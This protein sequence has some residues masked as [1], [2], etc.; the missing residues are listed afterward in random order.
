MATA[1]TT[2]TREQRVS[3]YVALDA[4]RDL[5]NHLPDISGMDAT[6]KHVSPLGW[7][8]IDVG[9]YNDTGSSLFEELWPADEWDDV[10]ESAEYR[11]ASARSDLMLGHLFTLLAN[12]SDRLRELADEAFE[13]SENG[14][15]AR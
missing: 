1:T 7:D 6:V 8:R 12:N 14:K 2:E 3:K 4:L 10:F 15:E 9:D 13:R 5:L 11:S